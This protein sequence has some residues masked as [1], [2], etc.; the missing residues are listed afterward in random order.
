MPCLRSQV[1][2]KNYFHTKSLFFANREAV[3]VFGGIDPQVMYG[4]EK[5]TG[6][7]IF[8][9]NPGKFGQ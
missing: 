6:R 9:Y 8:R 2:T 4:V 7:N 1:N 3:L 5:N